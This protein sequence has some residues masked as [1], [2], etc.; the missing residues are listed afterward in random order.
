MLHRLGIVL[1]L[2]GVAFVSAGCGLLEQKASAR[3]VGLRLEDVSLADATVAFDVEISNPYAVAL[4]LVNV[5][6]KLARQAGADFLTGQAPLQGTVPAG[7]TRTVTVPARVDYQNLI[8]ALSGVRLGDVV[9][10]AAEL[11]FSVDAPVIGA[12]RLPVRKQ[13]QLPVP[14][15]PRVSVAQIAWDELTL[16]QARGKIVLDLTNTNKFAM[17]LSKMDLDLQVGGVELFDAAIARAVSLAAWGGQGQLEIPFGV[18]PTNL[19]MGAFNVLTGR[20][21]TYS[22]TGAVEVDTPFAP[23]RIPVSA[24]G[25]T[26]FQR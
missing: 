16:R 18:S 23:M 15:P 14:A 10:Y 21:A 26:L 7:G 8:S 13:G 1:A 3:V 25:N 11:G 17:D 9:D 20:G 5:D 6:Y 2:A 4:P 24:T 19:G 22:L 12:L